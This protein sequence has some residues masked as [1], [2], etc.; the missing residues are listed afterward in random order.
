MTSPT[1]NPYSVLQVSAR[2]E[3]AVVKAASTETLW[4]HTDADGNVFFLPKRTEGPV[5][6]PFTGDLVFTDPVKTYL[7]DASKVVCNPVPSCA[8]FIELDWLHS[9]G[10]RRM[11]LCD[12]MCLREDLLGAAVGAFD[13]FREQ[14]SRV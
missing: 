6:S 9:V 5:V 7:N 4:K 14:A 12:E 1:K 10:Y 2:A 13:A 11:M 8:D 3:H